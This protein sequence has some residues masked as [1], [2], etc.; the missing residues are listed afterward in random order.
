MNVDLLSKMIQKIVLTSDEVTLPGF[1]SFVVEE[2]P[3]FFS[4]KGYTINPP[5]RKI[6]F[7]PHQGNDILLVEAFAAIEKLSVQEARK[8]LESFLSEMREVLKTKKTVVLPGL[9]KFRATKE[10]NF[11]F[12]CE[13]SLDIFP[14][15][16]GLESISLKNHSKTRGLSQSSAEIYKPQL[17]G[18]EVGR[19]DEAKMRKG[20]LRLLK[21]L[22]SV[23]AAALVAVA[24]LFLLK[25][26][27]PDFLDKI[28]YSSE[29]L[30]IINY[31]LP[32]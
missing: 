7:R 13:E 22:G 29:E 31:K 19:I 20:F 2:V 27:A 25:Y 3:A 14:E 5:Y 32:L 21:I 30:Q 10:N 24:V 17:F 1:G 28:L 11:F 8:K 15:G 23:A 26:V 9:G 4:N 12:V 18:N 6:A 16:F